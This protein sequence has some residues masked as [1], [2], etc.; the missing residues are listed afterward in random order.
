MRFIGFILAMI[1]TGGCAGNIACT[2]ESDDEMMERILH[3]VSHIGDS[4]ATPKDE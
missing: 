4:D 2:W 1:V 3:E